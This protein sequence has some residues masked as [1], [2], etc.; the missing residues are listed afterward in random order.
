MSGNSVD[1]LGWLRRNQAAH[2][3][4]FFA[5]D[6]LGNDPA[7]YGQRRISPALLE[8]MSGTIAPAGVPPI[9]PKQTSGG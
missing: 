1:A 6:D 4:A 7:Y 2:H 5:P 8:A 3:P 9:D